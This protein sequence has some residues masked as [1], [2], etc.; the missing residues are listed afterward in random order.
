MLRNYLTVAIRNLM[1]Q[2]LYAFINIF[3]LA[4]GIACCLLMALFVKHEWSYDRF[5]QNRGQIYRL[6]GREVKP[7]GDIK[8]RSLHPL[9]VVEPLV[10]TFP[11]IVWASGFMASTVRITGGDHTFS[12][13][14]GEAHADFLRMFSF[15]LLAGDA[16]TALSQPDAVVIS[17]PTARKFFGELQPGY[18][19]VLGRTLTFHGR[20]DETFVIT[21]VM[22]AVPENS[23]LRFDFLIPISHCENYGRTEENDAFTSVYVQLAGTQDAAALEAA[24]PSFIKTHQTDRI[25]T[26]L[27]YNLI[28]NTPD[29]YALRLQPLT[30]VYWNPLSTISYER[31]GN[32]FDA[33]LLSSIAALVLLI[34]CSNFTTLSIGRSTSRAR[35]VGIRKVVGAHR[36]QLMGQF[37]GE[38]I[39]LSF[40]SLG[41]GLALAELFLPI[42]NG[43]IQKPLHIAYFKDG[44]FLLIAVGIMV[45]VGLVAGSYPALVLS[46][47]QPVNA[48]K[49]QTRIGGRSHMT[50]AL[51][52]LQYAASIALM[53]CTGIIMKQQHYM[54]TKDLGFD[55]EHVV[56]V[57][58]PGMDVGMMKQIAERYKQTV[59]AH[60]Q[61]ISATVSDR[62]LTKGSANRMYKKPDGSQVMLRY[63]RV[64]PDYIKTMGLTLLEGRNFSNDHPTDHTQAILINEALVRAVG[65]ADPVGKPLIGFKYGA[66]ENPIIIGVVR[67]FH[68]GP[69]YEPIPPLVMQAGFGGYPV[70]LVRIQSNDISGTLALLEKTWKKVAPPGREFNTSFLDDNLDNQYR[71]EER[72]Q[73]VLS[74]SSF[75]A[76]AI[77]CLGLFGL[78]SLA[79]ARRTK[80]IG[81]RKVLGATTPGLVGLLSKDFVA[82]LIAANLIA[83]PVAYWAARRWL[84]NF[85]YRIEPG[86]GVFAL[87][88]L[89]ALVVALLTI[90][91]QTLKA[92]RAN[93]V[94]ALRYE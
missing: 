73:R 21:G 61:V 49:G 34:A 44:L 92:A 58:F 50:R 47:F 54:R 14:F 31:R 19:N 3:G 71:N 26:L 48:L 89:L 68:T 41:L 81:I 40:L 43:L 7:N 25:Q 67:D 76:V 10:K 84:E 17:E 36:G 22:Q 9:S 87:S 93:P 60:S 62:S 39:L 88:G 91:L 56:V 64:A 6:L 70:I 2:K 74:Y 77:S 52:A 94:E 27:K 8:I 65:L 20:K 69:L 33:Y 13:R 79:V 5:H 29:G 15:P 72:W 82:P 1:R 18:G 37:W 11:G 16:E 80:E 45:A 28:R 24:L 46:R 55:K 78:A 30:E 66:M 90:S 53:I 63:L 32:P 83:W 12:E 42:F 75:F 23:S 4:L 38:A 57:E 51:V 85:A 35:E 59:L 86:A